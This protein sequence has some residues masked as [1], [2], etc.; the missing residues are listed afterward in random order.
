MDRTTDLDSALSFVMGR[1]AEEA[2]RSGEPLSEQQ[3]FLLH[4]LPSSTTTN[5]L[6][7]VPVLVP[8]NIDLERLCELGKAAYLRDRQV[9]P[10]SLDWEFAFSVL[11]L[12]RHP[13]G[14]LLEWV[15]MRPRRPQ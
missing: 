15:G 9:N 2:Q 14:G 4:Y 5:W 11:R 1:I 8:R 12:N 13:M 3:R 7:E 10:T 6:P